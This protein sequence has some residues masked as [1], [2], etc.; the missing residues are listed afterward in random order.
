MQ[1]NKK[2]QK[3][4]YHIGNLVLFLIPDHE[5]HT[6]CKL[7]PPTEGPYSITNIFTNGTV[8]IRCSHIDEIVSICCIQPYHLWV[9][10]LICSSF[11]K[12]TSKKIQ[13][14]L[15]VGHHL[16][17]YTGKMDSWCLGRLTWLTLVKGCFLPHANDSPFLV[18]F[19]MG[20][21]ISPCLGMLFLIKLMHLMNLQTCL[22]LVGWA[23]ASM[24]STWDLSGW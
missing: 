10:Q 16:N 7:Q 23:I 18:S 3:H 21:S 14:D 5:W 11:T 13:G 22:A 17:L 12:K 24:A 8:S 20:S 1:K 4:T 9:Y 2:R 6:Q 19:V 15:Q